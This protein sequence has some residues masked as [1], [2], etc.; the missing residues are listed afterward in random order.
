MG[1]DKKGYR[2]T[3]KTV[4]SI[5]FGEVATWTGRGFNTMLVTGHQSYPSDWS[6][7]YLIHQKSDHL[8]DDDD[9]NIGV[10]EMTCCCIAVSETESL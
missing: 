8:S 10:L 3:D 7:Q 1:F 4:L 9:N 5:L 6:S 2:E